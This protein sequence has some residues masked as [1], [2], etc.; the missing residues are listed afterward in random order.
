MEA[1]ESG[2]RSIKLLPSM[3]DI[4]KEKE[5]LERRL[6]TSDEVGANRQIA[7]MGSLFQNIDEIKAELNV[8]KSLAG[9]SDEVEAINEEGG[10]IPYEIYS[11]KGREKLK[12]YAQGIRRRDPSIF[13]RSDSIT[14]IGKMKKGDI[15]A[16]LQSYDS[17]IRG[18][19]GT[20]STDKPDYKSIESAR[21]TPQPSESSGQSDT[22]DI[23]GNGLRKKVKM[24]RGV[25]RPKTRNYE[26]SVRPKRSDI[27]TKEDTDW[28]AGIKVQPRFIP[29]GRYIM[30][31]RQLDNNIV[32][33]RTPSGSNVP[34]FGS[35]RVSSGMGIVLRKMTGGGNPT[36]DELNSLTEE[37]RNYLNKIARVSKIDEKF[38]I[39][40]PNK[41]EDEKDVNQFEIM[42]GE[43]MAGND[44]SELVKKFKILIM[45]LAK[46]GLL[47][48]REAK[49]LLYELVHLGY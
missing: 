36:F 29:F 44:S 24:G 38:N 33:I 20:E 30:N 27:L 12:E 39:P 32:S 41:K 18:L 11:I 47:P 10:Y 43:I 17:E 49:D 34:L 3:A 1:L 31:K 48:Q 46:N 9:R 40:A 6:R 14:A 5:I 16:M 35:H 25:G 21:P 28:N 23:A 13:G 22:T 19:F 37:E 2:K 42:R 15:V 4:L 7:R 45:K 26:G 8:A